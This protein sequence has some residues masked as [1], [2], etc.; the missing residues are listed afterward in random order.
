DGHGSHKGLTRSLPLLLNKGPD[1][2]SIDHVGAII[3][4]HAVTIQK[5]KTAGYMRVSQI[6]R[7]YQ[8]NFDRFMEDAKLNTGQLTDIED[9]LDAW[10]RMDAGIGAA[11]GGNDDAWMD[12][13]NLTPSNF[14]F[15]LAG[16][17][18]AYKVPTPLS[19]DRVNV[20]REII[21]EGL[22]MSN[23]HAIKIGIEDAIIITSSQ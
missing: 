13:L 17:D 23:E 16:G 5:L 14:D 4:M 20:K 6:S 11:S 3:G 9:M 2:I 12:Q 1:N 21:D 18:A 22:G 7:S 15:G 10:T 19:A 8:H